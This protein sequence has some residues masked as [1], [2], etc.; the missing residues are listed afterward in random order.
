MTTQCGI[1][2]KD[3]IFTVVQRDSD[4]LWQ[5]QRGNNLV[6]QCLQIELNRIYRTLG[7]T[8]I[9]F[10]CNGVVTI[11]AIGIRAVSER[12]PIGS[13]K[14]DGWSASRMMR[15]TR[16]VIQ[17]SALKGNNPPS[18]LPVKFRK[19]ATVIKTTNADKD[20]RKNSRNGLWSDVLIPSGGIRFSYRMKSSS[21]C[22]RHKRCTVSQHLNSRYPA[23]HS[24]RFILNIKHRSCALF[25]RLLF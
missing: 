16:C 4:G 22:V 17:S 24:Y 11:G 8:V 12:R 3:V 7:V 18:I 25:L 6:C 14:G 15:S 13:P 10:I 20:N 2:I 19:I 5:F 21:V 1:S 23:A 9:G